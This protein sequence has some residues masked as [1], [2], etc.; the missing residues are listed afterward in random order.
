MLFVGYNLSKKYVLVTNDFSSKDIFSTMIFLTFWRLGFKD[1]C[2]TDDVSKA[3]PLLDMVDHDNRRR[4]V[5]IVFF[6]FS[7]S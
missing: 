5:S 7:N 1:V 4:V 6:S 2:T 3:Y